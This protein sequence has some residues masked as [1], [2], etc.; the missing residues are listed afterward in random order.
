[1]K[2]I[3]LIFFILIISIILQKSINELS[4]PIFIIDCMVILLFLGTVL[5][6]KYLNSRIPNLM[7]SR[8]NYDKLLICDKKYINKVN[9]NSEDTLILTNY[10]RNFYTDIKILERFYSFLH[11]K[12]ECIFIFDF[13]RYSYFK[14]K[15]INSMDYPFLHP[16][17]LYE[18]NIYVD[19]ILYKI[20]RILNKYKILFY[21]IGIYK[22]T[23][24]KKVDIDQI[25]TDIEKLN[26]FAK[27]R[28]IYIKI[29]IK[30][31]NYKL[32]KKYSNIK[33]QKIQ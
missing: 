14:N 7:N 1:M 4:I 10:N 23:N 5:E 21:K 26:N 22:I 20:N 27:E 13:N 24:N 32:L 19:S 3:I 33:Y 9:I 16:V 31:L 18:N 12:G 17:T 11:T 25:E 28:N 30:N 2:K 6:E 15:K 29:L 8:R